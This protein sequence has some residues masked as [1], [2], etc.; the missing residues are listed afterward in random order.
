MATEGLFALLCAGALVAA[1][2]TGDPAAN[3]KDERSH[4]VN[5]T[6]AVQTA[7]QQ[8]KEL[9]SRSRFREAVYVLEKELPR[10]NGSR[11]YLNTLQDAYRGYVKE[12][13]LAKKD[14]D[15]QV[16]LDRLRILDPGAVL[17]KTLGP[18]GPAPAAAPAPVQTQA[19]AAPVVRAKSSEEDDPFRPD[20][21]DLTRRAEAARAL[22][23][24]AEREFASRHYREARQLFDQAHQADNTATDA[25]RERWAYCRLACAFD[26]VDRTPPG[27]PRWHELEQEVRLA[28]E[29]APQA[30]A[31]LTRFATELLAEMRRRGGEADAG[32][33]VRHRDRGANGWCVTETANFRV[34]HN[35]PREYAEQVG[36]VA[37]R[38]RAEMGRRWFGSPGEDWNPKCDIYLHASGDEYNRATGVPGTSPGHSSISVEHGRVVGRKIDLHCDD[39]NLL[40]AVLPHETTHIV[41]AGQFGDH[42][43]PRWADEGI[44]VLSEPREKVERHLRNLSRCRQEGQVFNLRHLMQLGEYPDPQ[45]ISAFYA[46]S[47]SLVEFLAHERG[48]QVFTAFLRDGLR[49]GYESALQRHYGWRSFDELEQRWG[50]FVARGG[51]SP[52]AYAERS[53]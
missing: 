19:K 24:Q 1:G 15:A 23:A 11:T 10:I 47:V 43:V 48:H 35:Q 29:Q 41:L 52:T 21:R 5:D 30:D 3:P 17:D 13:R 25:C 44:A 9:L 49:E 36:R 28:M 22:V 50:S 45:H 38:T 18:A 16:Y 37:E 14:A 6:L 51:A 2:P 4:A 27:S 26:Q 7:L 46:Q 34:F 31:R 39:P 12:L 53:R 8:A 42:L 32:G 40:P 33:P 20:R